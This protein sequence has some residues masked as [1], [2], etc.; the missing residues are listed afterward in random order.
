MK[1]SPS[2]SPKFREEFLFRNNTHLKLSTFKGV[3]SDDQKKQL[4]IISKLLS[5][6]LE[7]NG[8]DL[9]DIRNKNAKASEKFIA[10]AKSTL[11]KRKVQRYPFP[12]LDIREKIGS[13]NF[14][15][16]DPSWIA[17]IS[18]KM[19]ADEPG[20]SDTLD[21]SPN[22]QGDIKAFVDDSGSGWL[23]IE[24]ESVGQNAHRTVVIEYSFI[25]TKTGLWTIF[26]GVD[27]HGFFILYADDQAWNSREAR[28]KLNVSISA[29]QYF[30]GPEVTHSILDIGDDNINTSQLFDDHA[31][32]VYLMQFKQGDPVAV[33]IKISMEAYAHGDDSYAELNFSNG[34]ANFIR[35]NG[36]FAFCD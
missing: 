23:G 8:F 34:A 17:V 21:V 15:K 5:K 2:N 1:K 32:L 9:K 27:L 10:K 26:A 16:V 4:K 29:S 13:E 18:H 25:P 24:A 14:S 36:L 30:P 12:M 11:S 31:G 6:S 3:K 20:V 35:P 33:T 28:I 7:K 19:D 22:V